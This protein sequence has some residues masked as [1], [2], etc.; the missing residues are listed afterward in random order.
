MKIHGMNRKRNKE[1]FNPILS[2]HSGHTDGYY[3]DSELYGNEPIIIMLEELNRKKKKQCR[4]QQQMPE[5]ISSNIKD[6]K[7]SKNLLNI[8]TDEYRSLIPRICQGVNR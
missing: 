1:F 4:Q 7:N 8:A 2:N 6:K 5:I 3:K